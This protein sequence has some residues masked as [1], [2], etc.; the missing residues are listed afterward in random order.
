MSG[1]LKAPFSVSAGSI[2]TLI[3]VE[4]VETLVPPFPGLG[5]AAEGGAAEI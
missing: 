2:V 1:Y 5:I 3:L 4:L